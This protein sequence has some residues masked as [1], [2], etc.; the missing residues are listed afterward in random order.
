MKKL[1][2]QHHKAMAA[3]YKAHA[4]ACDDGDAHKGLFHKLA[5][6]HSDLAEA[7]GEGISRGGD[8]ANLDGPR[9]TMMGGGMLDDLVPSN[10]YAIPPSDVPP[11]HLKLVGRYGAP[12]LEKAR[13]SPEHEEMFE[14]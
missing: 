10:I 13:V 3:T 14:V 4:D 2:H 1:L 12:T 5:A 8:G 6:H 9:K 7:L 11:A